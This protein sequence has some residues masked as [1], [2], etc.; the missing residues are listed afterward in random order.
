MDSSRGYSINTIAQQQ[1][2]FE[3][4]ADWLAENFGYTVLR[5]DTRDL[6][7]D[8][9][10]VDALDIINTNNANAYSPLDIHEVVSSLQA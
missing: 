6:S 2:A 10:A 1:S 4:L 8:Q 7:P 5:I 3:I 9:L